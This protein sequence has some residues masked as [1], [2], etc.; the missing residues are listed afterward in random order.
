MMYSMTFASGTCFFP[1]TLSQQVGGQD[2]D[3]L[4]SQILILEKKKKNTIKGTSEN[5]FFLN[6]SHTP[7]HV[8]LVS[9]PEIEPVPLQWKAES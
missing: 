7:Q 4:T 9:W 2:K 1:N 5:I 6:L 8:G 3:E